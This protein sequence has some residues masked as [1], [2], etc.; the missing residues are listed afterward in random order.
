MPLTPIAFLVLDEP[1]L[2]GWLSI[3]AVFRCLAIYPR[4]HGRMSVSSQPQ[5]L[6]SAARSMH[7][8]LLRD[9]LR[10]AYVACVGLFLIVLV[11]CGPLGSRWKKDSLSFMSL[12]PW[13]LAAVRVACRALSSLDLA[14]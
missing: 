2:V 3:I 12:V 8:L 13:A 7:P 11:A 5:P 1:L 14:P 9:G 10:S 6:G 4:P